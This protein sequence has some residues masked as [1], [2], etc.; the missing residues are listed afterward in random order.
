MLTVPTERIEVVP[1][2]IKLEGHD[3]KVRKPAGV[4]TIGYLARICPE[5]GL[6]HLVD[7]FVELASRPGG[8]GLRLRIAGYLGPRDKPF[9]ENCLRILAD[10]GLS[11]RVDCVG[12]VDLDGKMDFLASLDVL[13]VPTVYHEPKGIFV[14]EA[15]ASG[16]PVVQPAHGSFPEMIEATGGGILV[17]PDSPQALAD[18]IQRVLDEPDLRQRLGE[19]GRRSVSERFND[20]V[21]ASTMATVYREAAARR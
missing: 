20:D 15:M 16:V 18:G 17:E 2:G 3:R 1:L 8:S 4:K 13:S 14:L 7:A 12:E 19:A 21:M 11:E 6:H 9:L 5:K 10:A